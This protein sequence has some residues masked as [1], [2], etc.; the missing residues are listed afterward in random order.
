[1]HCKTLVIFVKVF[2][3][4]CRIFQN[5]FFSHITLIEGHLEK[6]KMAVEKAYCSKNKFVDIVM[7]VS[8]VG[9][10]LI[11]ETDSLI[12]EGPCDYGK[13]NYILSC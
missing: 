10:V 9:F 7:E 11:S 5:F 6:L 2:L 4:F 8:F 1:M 12:Q 13:A 3:A